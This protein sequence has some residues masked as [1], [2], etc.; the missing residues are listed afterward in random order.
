MANPHLPVAHARLTDIGS[1]AYTVPNKPS[2]VGDAERNRTA[3]FH[4]IKTKASC[5]GFISRTCTSRN[6]RVAALAMD[7]ARMQEN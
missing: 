2:A 1:S 5:V 4:R 7:V 3:Q 6:L